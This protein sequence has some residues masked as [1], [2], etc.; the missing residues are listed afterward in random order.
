MH[1]RFRSAIVIVFFAVI[2][3][4]AAA[5]AYHS[6]IQTPGAHAEQSDVR[7]AG[8][9]PKA[10]SELV[11]EVQ[12][13]V[14]SAEY[15]IAYLAHVGTFQSPNRAHGYR[16]T[17]TPSGL[18]IAPE[19]SAAA[20]RV[21]LDLER[22]GRPEHWMVPDLHPTMH[23][24][25]GSLTADHGPFAIDYLNDTCGV[26]QNF[27]VRERPLGTG[28]LEVRL[29]VDASLQPV[30]QGSN[31][32]AFQNEGGSTLLSYTDL[33]VWDADGDTLPAT[34]ALIDDDIVLLVDD[35]DADYP[36]VVDPLLPSGWTAES[37]QANAEFGSSVSSAGDVNGD[38]YS[39]V[40]VGSRLYDNGQADEGRVFV[41]HGS[42]AGLSPTASWTAES[43]QVAAYFGTSVS[44][45]G[46]VNGDGYSDVIIGAPAYDNGQSGEGRAFIY[47][48][49]ATGLAA[50]P[51]WTAES[52]QALASFGISVA[53]AGDV[54]GDG[55]S[56]VIVGAASFD[57]GQSNEGRAFVYHGS[58]S[59]TALTAAWTAESNQAGASFGQCVAG[60]GDVNGDGLSD[61]VIGAPLFDNGETDE[62]RT[63][64]YHGSAGGLSATANWTAEGNQAGAQFGSSV[65]SAGDANGDGYA[66]VL[67]GAPFY[68][69]GQADEGRGY[70]H[71]GSV[72]G[73]ALVS[74]WSFENDQAGSQLG[75]S[76][77]CLGDVNGDGISDLGLGAPLTD[78]GSVNSGVIYFAFGT[79]AALVPTLQNGGAG[80]QVD[81]NLG[82]SLSSGGDVNGDGWSD[83]IVG[84]PFFDNGQTNEGRV[85]SW[86]GSTASLSA[87]ATGFGGAVGALT[88]TSVCSAGDFDGDGFGD[89]VSGD[90]GMN[91]ARI[92]FGGGMGLNT[93]GGS[94]IS[95]PSAST[96][97]ASVSLAGDVNGDGYSDVIIGAPTYSVG[98]ANRGFV[99][100][101][102][103]YPSVSPPSWS[104]SPNLANAFMGYSVAGAGDVNGDGYSDVIIGLPGLS[105]VYLFQGSATGLGVTPTLTLTGQS[106]SRFGESVA[107]AGD[108]NG[109]GYADVIIGAGDHDAGQ[110][111]EGAA[112][113]HH[114]SASGLLTLPAW[115][116]EG[117]QAFAS[118]GSCTISS[119]ACRSAG[120]VNGDGFSDVIVGAPFYDNGQT[121]EGRV[122]VYSGSQAGLG[123]LPVWTAEKNQ[124]NAWFGMTVAS[125]GDVNGDGYSD[126]IIGSS[127]YDFMASNTGAAWVYHGSATGLPATEQWM[128]WGPAASSYYGEC[129]SGSGDVN[130]D[131]YSDVLIG[132]PLQT[133]S[134]TTWS[135]LGNRNQFNS[136]S[137]PRN[138][139]RLYNTDL[140]SPISAANLPTPLF[141]TGLYSTPFLGRTRTRLV[142]ET[143]IQG[144]P[145]SAAGGSLARSAQLTAQQA[146][147]TAGAP[148]GVELKAL[149]DKP[150]GGLGITATKVRARVRYNPATAITGQLYGPWRYMPGYLDGQGTHNNVPLP[151]ELL[152][153]SETCNGSLPELSWA[154]ASEQNSSH[155]AIERSADAT[156][157]EEI[158]QVAA[159]GTS[160]ATH[161][162]RFLDSDPLDGTISYYR[163]VQVDMDGTANILPTA[164]HLSC[165]A[166]KGSLMV[167]PNPATDILHVQIGTMS[168][169]VPIELWLLD[170]AGRQV[171]L[172]RPNDGSVLSS[173]SVQHLTPGTYDLQ[174]RH[175]DG[176]G[177]EHHRIVKQ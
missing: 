10:C 126:V 6:N 20:W 96:F 136:T 151:V 172:L 72:A 18:L 49:S 123:A 157:W 31:S 120:D 39:D 89:V 14:R 175:A 93:A 8:V 79:A 90:P 3:S 111:D 76:V 36:I 85:T 176:E 32:I 64:A 45:A 50:T 104:Y 177:I 71:I 21:A 51:A 139:M 24:S 116:A 54:N 131:G 67:S 94:L 12:A 59:G 60:A 43:D 7:S 138:N 35:R 9:A 130:G 97:G 4:W 148:G 84:A 95:G 113:V 149:V 75:W 101:V 13:T 68:D 16:V 159:A 26:R 133:A 52:D 57:N 87:G 28:P 88:G 29:R 162:Y 99:Q 132:A 125:A 167:F 102:Y 46:D 91:A 170:A 145:F 160:Q 140:A 142:W 92:K 112:F 124:A 33:H 153:F 65:S 86:D 106:M 15:D 144:Q 38:G 147:L 108:V 134:G 115:S 150:G 122:F 61:V 110:T 174:L 168:S 158:G 73:L 143:R 141:G 171:A 30:D 166:A 48:G 17:Y 169:D 100:V 78:F 117:D 34:M 69:G 163:L 37:D 47:L 173:F 81:A 66:D 80:G 164:A 161:E 55:F 129:V 74:L 82:R 56:E 154:T 103:G 114:G 22:I 121:D 107:G 44:T 23:S 105:Q 62:G 137:L 1:C 165:G 77:A 70:V 128:S 127:V 19:T 5:P 11:N 63:F 40:I 118:F 58:A 27:K 146:T 135:R 98:F 152:Y 53:C 83:M 155:F 41:Y 109:D 156:V 2:G 42:A 119:T 25:G